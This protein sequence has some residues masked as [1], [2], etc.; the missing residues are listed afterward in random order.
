[1]PRWTIDSPRTLD[2]TDVAALRVRVISG[3]VA[4]LASQDAPSL[5]VASLTGQPLL[6]T[7]EAG[8]LT[9]T[10]EDLQWDGLLGW[11]H[12][13]RHTADVT[14]TV[15][16]DC[17][18][19]V[20]VVNAS[21]IV[22]GISA[23][24]SAKSVS[25]DITLDGVIGNVD[26]KTV[27][28]DLEARGLDGEIAFNSVS[29]GLTLAGGTVRQLAAKT[30]SG[31]VTADVDLSDGGGLKVNTVSGD[32]AVRVP[33]SASARVSLKSASG[34]VRSSF[35]QMSASTGSGPATMSATIGSGSADL[36]LTS[37]TG[38]VTLL[39]RPDAPASGQ[40]P[41]D[42]QAQAGQ[43]QAGQ[44]EAAAPTATGPGEQR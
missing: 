1:M 12:P 22:S 32:V 42:G 29:G 7:H 15:P 40:P 41:A 34:R 25:G 5:D 19:Q 36:S 8:I 14:V 6:V 33:A 13:Q 11:L 4:I 21:A 24:I 35:D 23:N 38:D 28:G 3:S 17:P 26:A 31:Q 2:L 39:A 44:D 30:V 16:G 9:I 10:Y 43:A 20:G 18:A 37:M 27:S